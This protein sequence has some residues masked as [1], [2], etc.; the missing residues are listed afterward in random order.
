M[1]VQRRNTTQR[2][3]ILHVLRGTDEFITAQD[4]HAAL[5]TGGSGIGLA[6]VYRALQDMA[7]A[8]DLD[9][10]RKDSG[11]VLYRQCADSRHHHHLVCRHCGRTEEVEAPNVEK[12]ARSVAADH[13]F[14]DL[15]HELE[16]FGLCPQCADER[17]AARNDAAQPGAAG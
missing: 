13:G 8:G 11:E 3:E 6:T 16:L 17:T 7:G 10:V 5:R 12:W 1:V 2:T 9:T 15:D 14:V 4:L